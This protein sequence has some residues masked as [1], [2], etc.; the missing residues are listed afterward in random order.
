MAAAPAL[1][2]GHESPSFS[3]SQQRERELMITA[4]Q[5]ELPPKHEA[6]AAVCRALYSIMERVETAGVS[7]TEEVRLL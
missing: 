4:P 5:V 6:C 2:K 7:A 3:E 1:G